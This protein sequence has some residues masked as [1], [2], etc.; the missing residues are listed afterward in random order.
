MDDQFDEWTSHFVPDNQFGFVKKPGTADYGVT[1]AFAIIKH[2]NDRGDGKRGE[3]ILISLN[4][5]GAVGRIR[6]A[7][8]KNRLKAKGVRG[9]ALKLMYSYIKDR[10]IQVVASGDSSGFEEIFSGAPQ[11]AKWSPKLWNFD[12]SEMQFWTSELATLIC[13]A[14]DCG[15]WYLITSENPETIIDT[16]NID[17]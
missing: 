10:F 9:K 2:L 1:L 4:V 15:L 13:Y 6:W 3:G 17:L 11:G 5:A 16:I 7:R 8:L 12:I 14:D